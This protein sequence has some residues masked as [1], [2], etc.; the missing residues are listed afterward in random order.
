MHA[1]FIPVNDW[2]G[3]IHPLGSREQL[4]LDTHCSLVG[5]CSPPTPPS[6]SPMI[7]RQKVAQRRWMEALVVNP[8]EDTALLLICLQRA[9][10]GGCGWEKEGSTVLLPA[11]ALML[12]MVNVSSPPRMDT[13]VMTSPV[14]IFPAAHH[15]SLQERTNHS[16]LPGFLLPFPKL[17]HQ[18]QLP[19]APQVGAEG[20]PRICL[21]FTH[22]EIDLAQRWTQE[23]GTY[24]TSPQ[25]LRL[26]AARGWH[27]TECVSPSQLSF[28]LKGVV[29]P[30][31]IVQVPP[32]HP[33]A[34]TLPRMR[35]LNQGALV[36]SSSP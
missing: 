9:G 8:S 6:P 30:R 7:Q 33:T 25:K 16:L 31:N 28:M 3:R 29:S 4:W 32:H 17:S 14:V 22:T 26:E 1:L 21:S 18:P 13:P 10:V 2:A 36:G 34:F 24:G 19:K 35:P 5:P 20:M 27:K 11:D 23:M 15:Y 12:G